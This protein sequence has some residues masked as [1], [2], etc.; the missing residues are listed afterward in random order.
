LRFEAFNAFNH[1]RFA[2]PDTNPASAT[3][4][5]VTPSQLNN[6]RAVQLGAKL[7]F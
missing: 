7:A 4:G 5:R 2:A 3:F 6:S 1:P